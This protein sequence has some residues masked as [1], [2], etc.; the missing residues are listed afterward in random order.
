MYKTKRE[1]E[2]EEKRENSTLTTKK[3][4]TKLWPN[5]SGSV[6]KRSQQGRDPKV[7]T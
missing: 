5:A 6:E 4:S 7:V 2:K 3:R 1:E